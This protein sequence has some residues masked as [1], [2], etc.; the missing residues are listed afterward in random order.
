ME[1]E[2]KEKSDVTVGK[3]G[4]HHFSQVIKTNS[5]SDIVWLGCPL[6]MRRKA[7]YLP[8]THHPTLI[9]RKTLDKRQPRDI[10]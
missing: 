3:P 6:D 5:N 4:K 2:G 10:L 7:L 8:K 9:M 1:M